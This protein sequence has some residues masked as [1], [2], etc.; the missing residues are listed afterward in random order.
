MKKISK[1]FAAWVTDL[2]S[3]V[4]NWARISVTVLYLLIIILVLLIYSGAMY[5]SLL[6]HIQQQFNA[7]NNSSTH[8]IL[9]DSA[10]DNIQQQ[11]ILIDI[12]TFVVAAL[13][14][15][16]LAGVTLK[17]VKRALEA[18]EAFSADASHELRTPLAVIKTDIEVLL[19]STL[20]L[21]PEAVTILRSN[22]EE[23]N[24]LSDM[25]NELLE[26]SRSRQTS[27]QPIQ[28]E[29]LLQE[30]VNTLKSLARQ[31]NITLAFESTST[32]SFNGEARAIARVC[33]N[34]IANAITYTPGGGSVS[35]SL[36]EDAKNAVLTVIDDGI[37]I[38]D[39]DV[40]H[41]F[42]RFYKA[43][44]ARTESTAGSGLGLAIA[45]QIIEQHG[46]KIT[47]TSALQ[48]GTTVVITLPLLV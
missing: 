46:G 23:I 16:W 19:R 48:Q 36:K 29:V 30:E 47:I 21:P 34:V 10:I 17:P 12:G 31:K 15:Y 40:R 11:I 7:I 25:T 35:V 9:L 28:L 2:Q 32:R 42:K 41:V 38:S 6:H 44:N 27:R 13:G 14:S 8:Y 18:Q 45:K 33:K 20:A 22:L 3:N 43:D 39:H 37:G 5:F 24:A 26:L 1:R 4:F